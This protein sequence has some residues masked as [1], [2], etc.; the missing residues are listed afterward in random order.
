MPVAMKEA[1]AQTLTPSQVEL[2]DLEKKL[3]IIGTRA[4]EYR[5]NLTLEERRLSSLRT[6]YDAA[7]RKLALGQDA[8][9]ARIQ[10]EM[11]ASSARV[12]GLTTLVD[13]VR[14]E[15]DPIAQRHQAVSTRVVDEQ[16][17]LEIKNLEAEMLQAENDHLEK[18][19]EEAEASRIRNRVTAQLGAARQKLR[20]FREGRQPNEALRAAPVRR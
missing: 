7:C 20:M 3:N 17:S 16:M 15:Q 18:Q 2:A 10:A 8:D 12:Q 6:S 11:A 13:E 9:P 5:N 19:R 4:A 1:P 14:A